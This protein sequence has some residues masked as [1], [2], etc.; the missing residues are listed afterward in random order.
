MLV[1]R[2][3]NHLIQVVTLSIIDRVGPDAQVRERRAA[4]GDGAAARQT[5]FE[6]ALA[7]TAGGRPRRAA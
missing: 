3:L 5:E 7:K 2:W 6:R 1:A 4:V